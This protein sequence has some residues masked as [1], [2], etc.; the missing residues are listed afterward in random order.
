[1]NYRPWLAGL[2]APAIVFV[3][4]AQTPA[5]KAP[6]GKGAAQKGNSLIKKASFGQM[7]DGTPV[8]IYTLT[9]GSGMT[10]RITTYGG[11]VV[12]LTAP[13]RSGHYADIVLGMDDLKGYLAKPPYFGALIG[14]AL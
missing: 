1:M 3:C 10:A 2:A 5:K 12:S 8:D 9:N 7:P 13:D 4:L 6:A 11:A 14:R